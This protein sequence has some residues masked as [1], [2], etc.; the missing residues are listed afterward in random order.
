MSFEGK[1]KYNY[2]TTYPRYPDRAA[3]GKVP[4]SYH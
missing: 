2:L 4:L 3:M 1:K